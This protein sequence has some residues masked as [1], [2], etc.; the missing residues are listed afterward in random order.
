MSDPKLLPPP[1]P[2]DHP[3]DVGTRSEAVILAQ[4]AAWGHCVLVPFGVNQR[5]DLVLYANGNFTRVQCKT[6]RLRRGVIQ[7]STQ[8][9][10]TSKT[11]NVPRGYRG[12]AD[13]FL[14]YCADTNRIYG[15]PV[16]S[17]PR[18]YMALRVDPCRNGQCQGVNWASDYELPA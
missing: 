1:K 5:F 9:V 16:D 3:V 17:A 12:E 18:G 14:V 11:R 7:F 8:S 4:L 13:L 10:V 15:V 2:S 6:G